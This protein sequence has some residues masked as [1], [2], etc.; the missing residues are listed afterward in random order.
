MSATAN[1]RAIG[2]VGDELETDAVRGLAAM[3]RHAVLRQR[4]HGFLGLI[5]RAMLSD[6][7]SAMMGT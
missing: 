4:R 6:A 2:L 3:V 5:T 7:I 1:H